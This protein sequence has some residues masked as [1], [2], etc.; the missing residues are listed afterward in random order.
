[1]SEHFQINAEMLSNSTIQGD[2]HRLDLHAPEIASTAK[3]GQFVHVKL[4]GLEHRILRRPFS[5]CDTDPA[6]G[7][8]TIVYK[9]VGEGTAHLATIEKRGTIFNLLGPQGTPYT[10]NDGDGRF[11]IVAGGYGCAATYLL[12]KHA[13]VKPIVLIGGRSETDILLV[14]EYKALGCDVRIATNDGSAGCRGFVT[15]LLRE[16]LG[17]AKMVAACGPNPMLKAVAEMALPAGARVQISLDHPMC[18]GV[19]A[20][21]ACVVKVKD[22]SSPD[23]WRYSRSCMEG[24]VYDARDVVW[25]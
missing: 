12:A 8:L 24:P 14:E 5:I 11:V 15:E 18:C 9:T 3:P 17:D 25:A 20:C 7:R 10:V 6:T 16:C 22:D 2:Y 23:G 19:G 1:M 21:F 4:P 13:T